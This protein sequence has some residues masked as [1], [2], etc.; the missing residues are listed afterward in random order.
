MQ[1][2]WSSDSHV[3]PHLCPPLTV[4]KGQLPIE[5]KIAKSLQCKM[6]LFTADAADERS[7]KSKWPLPA[8][9]ER[10]QLPTEPILHLCWKTPGLFIVVGF[11]LLFLKPVSFPSQ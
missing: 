7:I 11:S 1:S 8:L 4:M 10:D 5:W 3:S 6:F 9:P 2:W